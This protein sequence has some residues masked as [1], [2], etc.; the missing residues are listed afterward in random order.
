MYLNR[1]SK[2]NR[3]LKKLQEATGLLGP[4]GEVHNIML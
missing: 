4:L 3:K 1:K 2:G